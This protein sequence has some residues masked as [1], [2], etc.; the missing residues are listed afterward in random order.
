[1][2][3]MF[4]RLVQHQLNPSTQQHCISPKFTHIS[5]LLQAK[6]LGLLQAH[7]LEQSKI[8]GTHKVPQAGAASAQPKH[9]TAVGQCQLY[10][11]RMAEI[12]SSHILL[13]FLD[14]YRHKYLNNQ[15]SGVPTMFPRLPK[16]PTAVGQYQLYQPKILLLHV[17]IPQK[18][19]FEINAVTLSEFIQTFSYFDVY[20]TQSS[21]NMLL[22]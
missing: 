7:V 19:F 3:T 8:W 13:I 14:Y 15:K 9:P 5:G 22:R 21:K 1:M 10:K 20:Y 2:P 4:P 17:Y 16:H 18:I 12:Q 11:P 6:V